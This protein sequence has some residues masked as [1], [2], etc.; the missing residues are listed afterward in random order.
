MISFE[1]Y[2]TLSCASALRG[3]GGLVGGGGD[4]KVI[5][6]KCIV[7]FVYLFVKLRVF[8]RSAICLSS[9]TVFASLHL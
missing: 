9:S 2:A 7:L 6:C 3:W 4:D 8:P 1:V 5:T